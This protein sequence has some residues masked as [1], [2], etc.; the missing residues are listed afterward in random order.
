MYIFIQERFVIN[1]G[2][3]LRTYGSSYTKLIQIVGFYDL[4]KYI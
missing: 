1:S 2:L 4:K 3:W